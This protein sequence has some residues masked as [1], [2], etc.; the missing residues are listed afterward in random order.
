LE[1]E[2]L[3][4]NLDITIIAGDFNFSDG[5]N[6]NKVIKDYSDIWKMGKR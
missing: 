4:E 1:I 6:E 2:K 3:N 5:W